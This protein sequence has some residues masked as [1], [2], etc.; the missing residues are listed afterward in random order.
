MT[1]PTTRR[2]VLRLIAVAPLLAAGAYPALAA[3]TPPID[4]LIDRSRRLPHVPERMD[5]ISH[6]LLGTRYQAN[7]LI[8]G[9]KRPEQFVVRDDAFDCVTFCEVVLAAAIARNFAEFE[10]ELRRIRYDHGKVQWDQRNH[11][12]ADWCQRNIENGICQPVAMEP[13][14]VIDKVVTWHRSLGR[15]SVSIRAVP[16]AAVVAH[17]KLLAPGDIVGFV[18]RRPNLDYYHTGLVAFDKGGTLLLRHASQSR[19]RVIEEPMARFM[20]VNP[21]KYVTLLRAADKS[22]IV[23]GR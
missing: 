9:P 8:G 22:Q 5:A 4:V 11:Y 20:A 12:F 6:A 2:N 3:K 16:K 15:R 17:V 1:N 23:Q 19:G 14:L 10:V 7:T 13:S 18:S 21:V